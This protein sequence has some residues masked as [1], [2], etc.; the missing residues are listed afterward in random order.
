LVGGYNLSS[1]PFVYGAE[2]AFLSGSVYEE[3]LNGVDTYPDY[4]FTQFVDLK[5]RL[6]YATGDFLVYGALGYSFADWS[7]S[8]ADYDAEGWLAGVGVDYAV[9]GKYFVGAEYVMRDLHANY[10][11]DATVNTFSVRAG[12]RF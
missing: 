11:F 7:E 4:E 6:G 5:G 2:I 12:I 10:P 9:G 1:G 8:G 3:D